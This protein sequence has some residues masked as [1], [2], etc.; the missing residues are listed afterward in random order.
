MVRKPIKEG[1][2]YAYEIEGGC[3]IYLNFKN[4]SIKGA[5][6]IPNTIKDIPIIRI[7]QQGFADC[8]HL[9]SVIIPDGVKEIGAFAFESC[10]KLN[11]VIIP[12]SVK[13]IE[14]SA[15]DG[16]TSLSEIT[17]PGVE[18]EIECFAFEGCVKLSTVIINTSKDK[19]SIEPDALP[20]H[21]SIHYQDS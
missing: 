19:I 20:E 1:D 18:V 12:N 17:I 9:T 10:V 3:E 2:Y 8:P 7:G 14:V 4:H 5:I 6:E 15:F 21:T 13:K 16:C 11:S